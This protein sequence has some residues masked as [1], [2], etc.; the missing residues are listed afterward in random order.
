MV[1]GEIE[2]AR[3]HAATHATP[4]ILPV[5]ID[6]DGPLPYPLNAYLDAIQ[7]ATWKRAAG[8]AA[9]APGAARRD[10]ARHRD[11]AAARGR[12]ADQA[13]RNLPPPYAA[14][15]PVPGGALD[16]EDPWYLP[17]PD[18]CDGAGRHSP[19][20]ADADHQGPA[21][22]GQ[23]LAADAHGESR[24]RHRQEGRAAG[25][26]AGRRKDKGECRSLL[27]AIRCVDRGAARAPRHGRRA[28]GRR[29]LQP[30]ELHPL[31]R[32]ADPAA[33]GRGHAYWRSTRRTRSSARI[34]PT[35]SS[36]CSGAGTA[37][38]PTRSARGWKKLDIVLSTSTEPQFFIERPHE[39]PFNVGVVLPLEDFEPDEVLRLN[40]LHPRPLDDSAIQRLYTLIGGH[41]YLTRKALYELASSSPS[42][43]L[44]ELFDEASEDTGP[45]RR[46][47][48]LLPASPAAQAG[49]DR[50]AAPGDRTARRRRRTAHPSAR[51]GGPRPPRAPSRRRPLRALRALLPRAAS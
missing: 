11:G 23:E 18:G 28:L 19:A 29:V 14:P 47:S 35:I 15:L 2:L 4:H 32:A 37:C 5:R 6:F 26:P 3:H 43:T 39:S 44:D 1:R 24:R 42:C 27:P 17:R 21:P 36:P 25:L 46:P 34:S 30:A 45:V 10:G 49:A 13:T 22:D 12:G 51:G 33:A 7:Y 20:G 8:N 40:A 9:A 48:A 31:R 50:R 38:A 16:V 41:P